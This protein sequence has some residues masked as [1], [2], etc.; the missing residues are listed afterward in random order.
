MNRMALI[1][2]SDH[3]MRN[4]SG[5]LGWC[6]LTGSVNI[7]DSVFVKD[8]FGWGRL[9]SNPLDRTR[10]RVKRMHTHSK[11]TD[12]FQFE[13]D[14]L[15]YAEGV[16]NALWCKPSR[17]HAPSRMLVTQKNLS[18]LCLHPLP[19]VSPAKY[20]PRPLH[21]DQRFLQFKVLYHLLTSGRQ[22]CPIRD[23]HI[24]TAIPRRLSLCG[25]KIQENNKQAHSTRKQG[26][27]DG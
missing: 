27:E 6:E 19:G 21:R 25:H 15:A 5:I 9:R 10:R 13:R 22:E 12:E 17:T 24:P 1:V 20:V 7:R 4:M 14:L 2:L 16:N 3:G 18:T 23:S 8:K 26:S 11:L